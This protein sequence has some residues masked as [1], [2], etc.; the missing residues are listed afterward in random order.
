MNLEDRQVSLT[1]PPQ[2]NARGLA[3]D[4]TTA[5]EE[6]FLKMIDAELTKVEKFTLEKVTELRLK[7]AEAEGMDVDTQKEDIGVLADSIANDFLRLE[8]F[9][10]L[11]FTAGMWA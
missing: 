11:N 3:M 9:V 8:K 2:T 7:I 4:N 5:T 6:S 1:T 10:N